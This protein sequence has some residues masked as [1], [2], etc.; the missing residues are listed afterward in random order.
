MNAG[1][2]AA[3][4]ILVAL[5]VMTWYVIAYFKHLAD[6]S[7]EAPPEEPPVIEETVEENAEGD[8]EGGLIQ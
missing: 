8:T 1:K 2:A 4:F 5:G 3:I 6:T 7:R